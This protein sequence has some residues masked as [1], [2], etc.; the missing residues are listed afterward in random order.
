MDG[1]LHAGPALLKND[2]NLQNRHGKLFI[3]FLER[4]PSLIVVNAL[5]VC[6][7]FITRKREVR[8]KAGTKTE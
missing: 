4:N 6:E 5:D 8:L 2:T 1:N 7:G 3:E